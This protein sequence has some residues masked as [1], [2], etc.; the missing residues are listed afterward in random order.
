M[1]RAAVLAHPLREGL[2]GRRRKAQEVGG[3]A[4]RGANESE[5]RHG[6]R[7]AERSLFGSGQGGQG[8][9]G[10]TRNPEEHVQ[11]HGAVPE[12]VS[13]ALSPAR[14]PGAA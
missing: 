6:R 11:E 13:S 12:G 1:P 10:E 9:E 4:D 14:K 5:D 7:G 3:P 2:E 8:Q